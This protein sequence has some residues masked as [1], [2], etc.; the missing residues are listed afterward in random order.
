M[1]VTGAI[2]DT[3]AK[4]QEG[5]MKNLRTAAT[6]LAVAMTA[7]PAAATLL[8]AQYSG[9][10]VAV[11][12][13]SH[14]GGVNVGDLAQVIVQ[15]DIDSLVDV[16]AEANA[17][18][19]TSYTKLQA[20]PLTALTARVGP[21]HFTLADFFSFYS[22]PLSVSAPYVVYNNGG[23]F[24]ISFFGVNAGQQAFVTA[25]P[26][27]E[28]YD[29]VGG[30]FEGVPGPSF[31]GDFGWKDAIITKVPEPASWAMMIAGFGLTGVALR[32]RDRSFGASARRAGPARVSQ[33][34]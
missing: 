6:V 25:G 8:Q 29:F 11:W 14:A 26:V 32:R 17:A 15:F 30:N 33:A 2:A 21:N 19:G 10:V 1:G 34:G 9:P 7:S 24:G 5:D 28:D 18:F 20:T 31:G 4:Q 22:D 12:D 13:T 27:P 16:T 23:F 3:W